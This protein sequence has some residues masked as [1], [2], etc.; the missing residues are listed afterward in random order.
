LLNAFDPIETKDSRILILGTLPSK[1]SLKVQEY[2]GHPRNAFWFIMASLC[3]S[4]FSSYQEKVLFLKERRIAVWDV[5]SAGERATSA[6]SDIRNEIPN[7]FARFWQTHQAIEL[8]GFNGLT[9][10]RLFHK[11]VQEPDIPALP[12]KPR[13]VTLPST[14]PAYT[15]PFSEKRETW[16]QALLGLI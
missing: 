4:S 12:I 6:D 3:E 11:H 13:F 2:Y 9:A 1:E 5:L 10:R 7:D 16:R 15:L 14:S 8:I